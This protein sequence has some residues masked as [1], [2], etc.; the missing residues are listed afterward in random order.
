MIGT[1][2]DKKYYLLQNAITGRGNYEVVES[3][4]STLSMTMERWQLKTEGGK[5]IAMR[6]I[7]EGP[8][9]IKA[10][11]EDES[12]LWGGAKTV[13]IEKEKAEKTK[14]KINQKTNRKK[15]VTNKR[16]ATK[17]AEK[18]NKSSSSEGLSITP[19]ALKKFKKGKK[20]AQKM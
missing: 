3:F 4:R 15:T 14:K 1:V 10:R 2:Y 19:P 5:A 9:P 6:K 13:A 17:E 16:K 8:Y 12:I 20:K 18:G 11:K 7:L